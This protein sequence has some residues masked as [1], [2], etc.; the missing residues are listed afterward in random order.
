MGPSALKAVWPGQKAPGQNRPSAHVSCKTFI[1][2]E[3]VKMVVHN[4]GLTDKAAVVATKVSKRSRRN[5]DDR[6][7]SSLE[8]FLMFDNFWV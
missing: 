6:L 3:G 8:A 5:P 2:G 1:V 7:C 4:T